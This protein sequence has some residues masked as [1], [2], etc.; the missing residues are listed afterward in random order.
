MTFLLWMAAVI[1]TLGGI[2]WVYEALQESRDRRRYPPPGK[3]V[4]IGGR[5]LHIFIQGD[6]PGPTVVIEQGLASP[7]IVWWPLQ[8]T[9]AK[10]ARVCTY[11]RAGYL[12]SDPAIAGRNLEDRVADLHSL[13]MRAQVPAPYIFVAHSLGGLIVRHFAQV[14]P[15]LVVGMVLVDSPDEPVIFRE[16][17]RASFAQG[18]RM[19]GIIRMAARFGLLRLLGRYIPMLMLPDDPMGYALCVRPQHAAASADDMRAI[20]DASDEIRKPARPGSLGDRPIVLLS[21]GIPFPPVAA[22]MEEG[23][24]DG[25]RRLSDLSTDGEFVVAQRSGHLIHVDE[26]ELVVDSVR[27][28]HAAVRAGERLTLS[29]AHVRSTA[30]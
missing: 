6:A 26:P 16:S 11:D 15:N 1:I 13:L 5:R 22:A 2:L 23:W 18:V 20:L 17:V 29:G 30:A 21:H 27:R 28:V 7:S 10:F 8:A 14:H 3:L 19:Q 12:W 4:E 24:T 25:V 9:I